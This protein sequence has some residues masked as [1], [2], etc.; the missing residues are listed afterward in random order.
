VTRGQLLALGLSAS[1]IQRMPDLFAAHAGVYGVGHREITAVARAHAAVLACGEGAILSHDSAAALWGVGRWP[2]VPEVTARWDVR[3]KGIRNHRSTTLTAGDR[4]IHHGI[5][6]TTPVRTVLDVACR[7]SDRELIRMVN[8]LRLAAYLKPTALRQLLERS[9]RVSAL[10]DPSQNPSRSGL[11]DAFL[12]WIARHGLPTPRINRRSGRIEPDAIFD[13][14]KVIVELDTY[15]THGDPTHFHA[16]RARDRANADTGHLT[17]RYTPADL[18]DPEAERL[19]RI[20]AARYP[21]S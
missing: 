8:D 2:V 10:I 18:T 17:L 7:R 13:A 21:H 16:D 4:T 11:E 6:V 19:H 15:G 1:A 3:R 20:L 9:A 12:V 14:H 5:A